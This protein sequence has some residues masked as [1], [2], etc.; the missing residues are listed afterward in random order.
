MTV[1]V[2]AK[3]PRTGALKV[4]VEDIDRRVVLIS[5]VVDAL[6]KD[7]EAVQDLIVILQEDVAS[8]LPQDTAWMGQYIRTF[9]QFLNNSMITNAVDS[10]AEETLNEILDQA[11]T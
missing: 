6:Q 4:Q 7:I 5:Q 8:A 2:E 3:T 11:A 1:M 10:A 9:N